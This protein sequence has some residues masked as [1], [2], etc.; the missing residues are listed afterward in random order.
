MYNEVWYVHATRCVARLG[1]AGKGQAG[2]EKGHP[3]NLREE[4]I[5][6]VKGFN[7]KSYENTEGEQIKNIL[8]V[9]SFLVFRIDTFILLFLFWNKIN[10][11]I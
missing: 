10:T 7:Q 9:L 1:Q 6:W 4:D 8:S 5:N 3:A 2:P 11:N